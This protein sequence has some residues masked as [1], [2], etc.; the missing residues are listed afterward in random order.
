VAKATTGA[1][2]TCCGVVAMTITTAKVVANATR[3]VIES[4]GNVVAHRKAPSFAG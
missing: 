1:L 3:A 4:G 2:E